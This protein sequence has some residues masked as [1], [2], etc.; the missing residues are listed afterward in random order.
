MEKFTTVA[1]SIIFCLKDWVAP[2]DTGIVYLF[3][4]FPSVEPHNLQCFAFTN[5]TGKAGDCRQQN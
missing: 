4:N 5:V 3:E 2:L 1:S